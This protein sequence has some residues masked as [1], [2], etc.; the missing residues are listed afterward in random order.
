M[1]ERFSQHLARAKGFNKTVSQVKHMSWLVIDFHLLCSDGQKIKSFTLP[2]IFEQNDKIKHKTKYRN[3]THLMLFS[4]IKI[5]SLLEKTI[6]YV[7]SVYSHVFHCIL[8][9]VNCKC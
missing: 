9:V 2:L 3:Q 5:V 6:I 8:H 7:C 4:T 1:P